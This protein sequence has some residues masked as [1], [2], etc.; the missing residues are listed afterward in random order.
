MNKMI[1]A[2][3]V[4]RPLRSA[5]SMVAVRV[6]LTLLLL[7]V[8]LST[9]I[10]NDNKPRQAGMGADIMV[11]PPGSSFMTGLTG[12][13]V[14]IRVG[15]ILRK[16]P[17]IAAVTPVVT[18]LTAGANIEIIY[19]IDVPSFEAVGGPLRFIEGTAFQGP[20]DMIVDDFFAG[21]HNVHAGSGIEI[22]NH[23]F[24]V[25]GIVPNGRGARRYI[26]IHTMHD[27][28]VTENKTS[29]FYVKLDDVKNAGAVAAEINR[30]SGLEKYSVMTMQAWLSLMSPTNLPGLSAFID[31]VIGISVAISFLVIFQSKDTA[32]RGRNREIVVRKARAPSE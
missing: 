11:K 25:C 15:D 18:Q 1:V 32:A 4:Y 21:A 5:I 2:N 9:G 17:H 6:K 29:I 19:G 14:P 27:L 12:A 13:P 7:I 26:E 23:K 30:I 24:R 3:L 28:I 16:Q 10:P 20:D 31:V 8:G 22:L